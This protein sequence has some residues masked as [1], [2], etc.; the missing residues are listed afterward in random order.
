MSEEKPASGYL[1]A[2]IGYVLVSGSVA[3]ADRGDNLLHHP[4]VGRLFL[5]G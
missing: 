4:D 3:M 1:D 5:G 2:D